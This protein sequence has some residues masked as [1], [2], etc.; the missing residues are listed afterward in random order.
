MEEFAVFIPLHLQFATTRDSCNAFRHF[1]NDR[2]A[3]AMLC[4]CCQSAFEE[5]TVVWLRRREDENVVEISRS[6]IGD[7]SRENG[8]HFLGKDGFDGICPDND[9]VRFIKKTRN[10]GLA[11]F[12]R[13]GVVRRHVYRKGNVHDIVAC[14]QKYT[15]PPR[16]CH[17]HVWVRFSIPKKIHHHER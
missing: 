6:R 5:C 16:R 15:E 17:H 13:D 14:R 2:H 7:T 11:R 8:L 3:V 12:W 9:F 4:R 1:V 10:A